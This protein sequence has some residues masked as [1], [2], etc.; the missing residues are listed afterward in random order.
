MIPSPRPRF[1]APR[2]LGLQ[3]SRLGRP[4][5]ARRP[6]GQGGFTLLELIVVVAMIGI[7]AAIALPNLI[8]T[9]RRAKEAVL[10]TNLRTIREVIDQHYGDKGFYPETLDALV[11]EGYLRDVPLDPITEEATWGLVYEESPDDINDPDSIAW[12]VDLEV[13]GAAGI[14]D[15][16]SLS[17]DSSLDGTPYAEW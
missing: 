14:I 1:R 3:F 4:P 13:G 9:P 17:E 12:G 2:F 7:L 6:L 10:R 8:Q 11:E 5:S 16:Y 15:V